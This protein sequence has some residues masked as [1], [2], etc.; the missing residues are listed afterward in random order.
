MFMIIQSGTINNLTVVMPLV[1]TMHQMTKS[2][3]FQ[4]TF[5]SYFNFLLKMHIISL[6][7]LVA[8]TLFVG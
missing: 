3:C 2:F 7:H 8:A 1:V 4:D 6:V 5:V